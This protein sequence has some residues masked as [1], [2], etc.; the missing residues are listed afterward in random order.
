MSDTKCHRVN[1][2]HTSLL[3]CTWHTVCMQRSSSVWMSSLYTPIVLGR[4]SDFFFLTCFKRCLSQQHIL[5]TS[6]LN[7]Q[8]GEA[9]VH[10]IT[11][12]LDTRICTD[13][14]HILTTKVIRFSSFHNGLLFL[15]NGLLGLPSTSDYSDILFEWGLHQLGVH[16]SYFIPVA[17]LLTTYGVYLTT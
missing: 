14:T 12:F 17:W 7:W 8:L 10:C 6:S 9:S 16:V 1:N 3:L 15:F 13:C 5:Q 11:V 4:G 2:T